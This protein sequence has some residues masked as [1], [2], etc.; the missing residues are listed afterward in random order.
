MQLVA[1]YFSIF[2]LEF[3]KLNTFP[4]SFLTTHF[5]MV[6]CMF[7]TTWLACCIFCNIEYTIRKA[8]DS[9]EHCSM[10]IASSFILHICL[11][12]WIKFMPHPYTFVSSKKMLIILFQFCFIKKI[13]NWKFTATTSSSIFMNFF[14]LVCVCWC[15][16]DYHF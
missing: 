11:Y 14:S 9:H 13:R 2:L 6:Y 16:C 5:W 8:L 3:Q 10:V 1:W 4:L 12:C 7:V 15:F